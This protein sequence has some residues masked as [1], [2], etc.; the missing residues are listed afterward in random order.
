M[1]ELFGR[2]VGRGLIWPLGEDVAETGPSTS[3][4]K[5]C[6]SEKLFVDYAGDLVPL[7]IDRHTGE[8][9][10]RIGGKRRRDLEW[11]DRRYISLKPL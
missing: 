1:R 11:R 6:G 4:C 9:R 2:F 8:T 3:R 5:S 7:M 10:A